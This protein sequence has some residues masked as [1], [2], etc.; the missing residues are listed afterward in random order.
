MSSKIELTLG[1]FYLTT[2]SISLAG[3]GIVIPAA[4]PVALVG[5]YL[6]PPDY[7]STE[8]STKVIY[9]LVRPSGF[10]TITDDYEINDI[11]PYDL[12]QLRIR[13]K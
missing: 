9:R 7:D 8:I 2:R 10:S 11:P 13:K 5:V 3:Y 1:D 12:K 6:T 4:S